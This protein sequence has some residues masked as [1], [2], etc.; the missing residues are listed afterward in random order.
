M[1]VRVVYKTVFPKLTPKLKYAPQ[2]IMNSVC[3]K[4][5]SHY[6]LTL[7]DVPKDLDILSPLQRVSDEMTLAEGVRCLDGAIKN[8]LLTPAV[9]SVISSVIMRN[10]LFA[11]TSDLTRLLE[12]LSLSRVNLSVDD[13]E[14]FFVALAPQ[15][16]SRCGS[17]SSIELSRISTAYATLGLFERDLF[18]QLGAATALASSTMSPDQLTAILV[19]LAKL[20]FRHD[21][22]FVKSAAL[23]A[24]SI[25]S[26][27]MVCDI[28]FS[29]ARFDLKFPGLLDKV[30]AHLENFTESE[31]FEKLNPVKFS[32]LVI[33]TSRLNRNFSL[34]QK[35]SRAILGYPA[36][37]RDISV[38]TLLALADLGIFSETVWRS[39]AE[40]VILDDPVGA[41]NAVAKRCASPWGL[42]PLEDWLGSFITKCIDSVVI[43]QVGAV[44]FIAL[45]E[46]LSR[47][48]QNLPAGFINKLAWRANEVID[49]LDDRAKT[50]I[51][52]LVGLDHPVINE[53]PVHV[54]NSVAD[55]VA[56][57]EEERILMEITSGRAGVMEGPFRLNVVETLD[58]PRAFIFLKD[59]EFF[60]D[61]RSLVL[62]PL[63]QLRISLVQKSGWNVT[64]INLS[65]FRANPILLVYCCLR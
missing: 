42:L 38:T 8:N 65:S 4:D 60:H 44:E 27:D 48:P 36:A 25:L 10:V 23:L 6:L 57:P 56:Y 19:A 41:I 45:L 9:F 54:F 24:D 34:A 63:P 16:T 61:G 33:S 30:Y 3:A 21:L 50:M 14:P 64:S 2:V 47:L 29:Y 43:E 5:L 37:W 51:A 46:G 52:S 20:R 26:L 53:L 39:A 7:Y 12:Q 28:L 11:S 32:D 58:E 49:D 59:S 17:A 18:T 55:N 31:I 40:A 15:L 62:R 35:L 22:V 1:A 13:L